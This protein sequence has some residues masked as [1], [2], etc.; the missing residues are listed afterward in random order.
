ME[1]N[2]SADHPITL[3]TVKCVPCE[4]MDASLCL[5]NERIQQHIAEQI[6]LWTVGSNGNTSSFLTRSFLV[7]NFQAA[8]D[9]INAMGA[10]AEAESHH[11]DFHLTN[12]R[13]LQIVIYTH[14]LNGV[15][16]NDIVLARLIDLKVKIDYSPKWLREN[17]QAM[18]TSAH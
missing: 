13:Q 11:P 10:V 15:T 3:S 17:P 5:S 14:K 9:C 18:T 1:E 7:R 12:Y 8:L 2:T 6:P 4:S 16:N